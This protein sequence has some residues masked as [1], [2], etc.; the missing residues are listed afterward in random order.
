MNPYQGQAATITP[1]EREQLI[2]EHMPQVRLIAR[3]IHDRLPETVSLEDLVSTGVV[4]LISAIDR[5]DPSHGVKLKTYAEYKIRGAILDSLRG[6]DWAPR[7]QRRRSKLIELAIS[8]LEQS[9]HRAPNEEEIAAE[10]GIAIS[11]YRDWL[12]EIRGLN[13]GSLESHPPDEDGRELLRF[14]ADS[15]ESWPSNL[16]ER[17]ELRRILAQAIARMPAIERTVLG[18]YF[19]EELTLREIASVIQL[20]ESRVS[21]LKTQAIARLRA[22]L[23]K[24]WPTG[25]G[26]AV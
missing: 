16:L 19:Q 12:T 2:L 20:H 11:E 15:E 26:A 5:Y 17:A 8:N 18:L 14:V 25:R 3:R 9:L 6:L 23:K 7:Q 1:E 24:K 10:L 13:L 22:F 4:G 21:Q